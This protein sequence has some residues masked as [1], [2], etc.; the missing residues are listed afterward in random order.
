VKRRTFGESCMGL[1]LEIGLKRSLKIF[2]E[3]LDRWC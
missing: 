3:E 2:G 1:G